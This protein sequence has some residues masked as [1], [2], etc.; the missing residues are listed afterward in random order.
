MAKDWFEGQYRIDNI[1]H[2]SE[3]FTKSFSQ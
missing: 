3:R 1:W 2:I